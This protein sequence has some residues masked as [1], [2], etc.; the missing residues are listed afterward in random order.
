MYGLKLCTFTKFRMADTVLKSDFYNANTEINRELK[1]AGQGIGAGKWNKTSNVCKYGLQLKAYLENVT[2]LQP[3][4]QEIGWHL[5][6]KC[7]RCDEISPKWH[8]VAPN[9]S[10]D[11]KTNFCRFGGLAAK[12]GE[13]G[14]NS[15]NFVIK[16]KF[17]SWENFMDVYS[18]SVCSYDQADSGNFK[19]IV[20]F[21]C[22]GL[23]PM[24]YFPR[25]N[26]TCQGYYINNSEDC[27]DPL[28]HYGDNF[29]EID[30]NEK[31][32]VDYDE[33]IG[34]CLMISEIE[35]QFEVVK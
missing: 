20:V 12:R 28:P 6:L 17:C 18:S 10:A 9:E 8:C 4:S 30:L 23:V 22:N 11:L 5:K 35:F 24:E 3:E 15:S 1:P 32:W 25:D 33:F 29:W 2:A 16:C 7:S 26:W 21:A 19:T 13:G 14:R 34:K 31:E 27:V